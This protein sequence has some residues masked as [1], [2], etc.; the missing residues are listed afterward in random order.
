MK[1]T[2]NG[3]TLDE[4]NVYTVSESISSL[5]HIKKER[6]LKFPKRANIGIIDLGGCTIDVSVFEY[7]NGTFPRVLGGFVIAGGG[8]YI[9]KL[10]E[11]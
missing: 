1:D 4:T 9:N 11:D 6:D 2:P 7:R 10:Y 3:L 8:S 5:Y